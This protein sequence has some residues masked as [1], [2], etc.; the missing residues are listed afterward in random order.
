MVRPYHPKDPGKNNFHIY[1]S[2]LQAIFA[3]SGAQ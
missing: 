3:R 1:A 2:R